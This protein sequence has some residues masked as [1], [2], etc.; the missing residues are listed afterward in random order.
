MIDLLYI[1]QKRRKQYV[2]SARWKIN[3]QMRFDNEDNRVENFDK[4]RRDLFYRGGV[5]MAGTEHLGSYCNQENCF[6]AINRHELT[7][8]TAEVIFN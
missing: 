2:E 5:L 4:Y 3:S 7:T 8:I 6:S 1:I